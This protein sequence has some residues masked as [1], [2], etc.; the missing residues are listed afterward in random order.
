[1]LGRVSVRTGVSSEDSGFLAQSVKDSR[2]S[3]L[4]RCLGIFLE[5]IPSKDILC[6]VRWTS[7]EAMS[8]ITR[9]YIGQWQ[10]RSNGGS[11]REVS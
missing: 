10:N 4:V 9:G 2:C 7:A 11:T 6:M 5:A 3:S 8:Q 1:M